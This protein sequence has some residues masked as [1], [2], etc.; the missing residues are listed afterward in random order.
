MANRRKRH[1]D[2]PYRHP[3]HRRPVTRREFLGQGFLSGAAV[4]FLLGEGRIRDTFEVKA[5]RCGEPAVRLFLQPREDATYERLELL[6]D[7]AEGDVRETAVIDLFGNRTDVVFEGLRTNLSPGPATFRF[8]PGP[9]DRVLRAGPPQA[10]GPDS[11][12]AGGS[13][14]Q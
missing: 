7:A 2:E 12:A 6:V 5:E 9:D 10:G 13:D 11:R 1:P 3:D 8:T 4:S 14:S